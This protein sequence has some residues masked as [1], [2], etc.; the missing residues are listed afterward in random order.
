MKS[1]VTFAQLGTFSLFLFCISYSC[2]ENKKQDT[3][4]DGDSAS[5]LSDRPYSEK[6][7]RDSL[8]SIMISS[9]VGPERVIW[10][11]PELIISMLGDLKGKTVADIGAGTG[12]FTFRLVQS[13]AKVYACDIDTSA[14]N[15]LEL[16]ARK[17][18]TAISKKIKVVI[19]NDKDPGLGKEKVD[20]VF[21]SNTYMYIK[22]RVSYLKNLK[23]YLKPHSKIMIVDYKRKRIPFGPPVEEKIDLYQV[24]KELLSAGYTVLHSDDVSLDYQYIVTAELE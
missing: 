10:Q 17:V 16:L 24:E 23:H 20:I 1:I 5:H 18:D 8:D 12:F 21:L 6:K 15:R 9:D 22:N 4:I 13:A 2:R 19:S 3:N 14:L 11:K 7:V